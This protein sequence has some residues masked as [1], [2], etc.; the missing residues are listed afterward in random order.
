MKNKKYIILIPQ[1]L[2]FIL[3]CLPMRVVLKYT[4]APNPEEFI[5][6]Y[7]NYF[8]FGMFRYTVFLP[9]VTAIFTI[10]I[11]IISIIWLVKDQ[12]KLL[13]VLRFLTLIHLVTGISVMLWGLRYVSAIGTIINGL[14]IAQLVTFRLEK[15]TGEDTPRFKKNE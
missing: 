12:R 3:E 11:L 8:D 13:L 14:I 2:I 7:T 1:I 6:L 5:T 4:P 9:F 10:V 15:I